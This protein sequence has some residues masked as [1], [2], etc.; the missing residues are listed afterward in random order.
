MGKLRYITL[1]RVFSILVVVFFHC[2]QMLYSGHIAEVKELYYD[3]Y[4]KI[5]QCGLINIAMPLF[6]TI[7]GYLFLYISNKGGYKDFISFIKNKSLRLLLPYFVFSILMILTT[8]YSFGLEILSGFCHL[9]F[10]PRLFECFI[11]TWIIRRYIKNKIVNAVILLLSFLFRDI[12]LPIPSEFL[13]I[14]HILRWWCW[15]LLGCSILDWQYE[16]FK[17]LSKFHLWVICFIPYIVLFIVN[18]VSYGEESK[19]IIPCI[20]VAI[21]GM[22]HLAYKLCEREVFSE[23]AWKYIDLIG[24]W[25]YGLFIFHFWFG[26]YL[27]S[28]IVQ[29]L[30]P[31]NELAADYIILFPLGFTLI[32]ITISIIATY[33]LQRNR[34]GRYL[35]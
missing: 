23:T 19:V 9:W 31:L 30:I 13:G 5:I 3:Y 32:T 7:S 18:P 14:D 27:L 15:F 4:Y 17:V 29:K 34:I 10:L 26:P 2:Y 12:I 6:F 1:L 20:A 28:S 16:I 21:L 33:I 8:G 22:M 35:V 25:S 24:K 11:L